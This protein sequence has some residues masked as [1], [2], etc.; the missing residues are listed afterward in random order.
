MPPRSLRAVPP[1]SPAEAPE[2]PAPDPQIVAEI[3]RILDD[4]R[5]RL[6]PEALAALREDM[7]AFATGHPAMV[8]LWR[9]ARPRAVPESSGVVPTGE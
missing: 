8:E 6:P 4:A 9:R 2:E 1:P 3:D 7:L 5:D